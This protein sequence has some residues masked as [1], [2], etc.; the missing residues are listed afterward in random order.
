M[1]EICTR[2]RVWG[3]VAGRVEVAGTGIGVPNPYPYPTGAI[4]SRGSEQGVRRKGS[5]GVFDSAVDIFKKAAVD[6]EL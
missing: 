6:C 4:H 2:Q 5:M 1:V 3:R